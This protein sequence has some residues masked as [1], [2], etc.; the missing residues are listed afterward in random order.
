MSPRLARLPAFALIL[1]VSSM[2]QAGGPHDGT[3]TG[4]YKTIRNDNSGNCDKL[5]NDRVTITVADGKFSRRW[6]GNDIAVTV[7]PD[8]TV[9][10]SSSRAQNTRSQRVISFEGR[11][12]NGVMEGEYGH[13]R[14]AVRFSLRKQ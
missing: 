5:D 1:A 10:G 14:C 6:A 9:A 2:A 12:A 3:W 11:I 13:A 8:G 4:S 7:A